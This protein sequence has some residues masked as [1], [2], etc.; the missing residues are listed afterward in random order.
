MYVLG[1]AASTHQF[2]LS[3]DGT[4]L[5]NDFFDMAT[6]TFGVDVD[7]ATINL[8]GTGHDLELGDSF[9]LVSGSQITGT[10]IF[11]A[12]GVTF[13]DAGYSF[14]TS[15][16]NTT[17]AITVIPE[18]ATLGLVISAGVGLLCIRRKFML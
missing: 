4:S 15:D 17:G 16:F 12:D 11:N 18:P 14:D 9:T 10:A 6:G 7:G 13:A 3:K 5:D 1:L 2:D 8:V